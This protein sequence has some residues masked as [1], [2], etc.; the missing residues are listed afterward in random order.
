MFDLE[1]TKTLRKTRK[2]NLGSFLA[3]LFCTLVILSTMGNSFGIRNSYAQQQLLLQPQHPSILTYHSP[4]SSNLRNSSAQ[5]Q[6]Q[7][8]QQQNQQPSTVTYHSPLSSN[9]RNS[10]A[11]QQQQNQQPST[12]AY[13]SPWSNNLPI[14]NS[15]NMS[16][17]MQAICGHGVCSGTV[18]TANSGNRQN[19]DSGNTRWHNNNIVS[20]FL[21]NSFTTG[22]DLFL[23]QQFTSN[24]VVG[25]DRFRFVTS[26]WT[27]PDT[28]NGVDVGTSANNTFLAANSLPPNPK[29][30][31]D[32]NEGYSTLAVAL[33]YQGVVQLAGITAALKLP[34]GFKAINP[35]TSD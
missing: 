26:Y 9:L 22:K 2:K 35:L 20:S 14:S 16:N 15:G 19:S 4:L 5:Q 23:Q 7:Q 6:Q 1:T 27:T 10:S 11:Q 34:I 24:K 18:P 31:V 12:V 21:T 30:E 8:Q 25:P 28:S 17:N 29:L 33:Q 13:H 32:T 3:M